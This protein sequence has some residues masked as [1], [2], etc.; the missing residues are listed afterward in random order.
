[1]YP[2]SFTNP[3]GIPYKFT[4]TSFS[5]SSSPQKRNITKYAQFFNE[6]GYKQES[7][8]LTMQNLETIFGDEPRLNT[9]P[10]LR[11]QELQ[12]LKGLK[13]INCITDPKKDAFNFSS[14]ST[15]SLFDQ[16]QASGRNVFPLHTP[17]LSLGGICQDLYHK[18]SESIIHEKNERS[19]IY[20]QKAN[21][22]KALNNLLNTPSALAS[23]AGTAVSGKRRGNSS[24]L[25]LANNVRKVSP[26]TKKFSTIKEVIGKPGNTPARTFTFTMNSGIKS[27]KQEN[28]KPLS[29]TIGAARSETSLSKER[30][31]K[32]SILNV[33]QSRVLESVNDLFDGK[34]VKPVSAMEMGSV[35]SLRPVTSLHK[36]VKSAV[37]FGQERPKKKVLTV[38]ATGSKVKEAAPFIKLETDCVDSV[39]ETGMAMMHQTKTK[40]QD[41]RV[42]RGYNNNG[43]LIRIEN[44][45]EV[46]NVNH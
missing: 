13:S 32:L 15:Y 29:P 42:A 8:Q 23:K 6:A 26:E 19:S 43:Y 14:P 18:Q 27:L 33:V 38:I 7:P 28:L 39:D 21:S 10:S 5:A 9:N 41:M 4:K 1:M 16:Y 44:V 17:S 40:P 36:N 25:L 11:F 30:K 46:I 20:T 24:D 22:Y 37:L 35:L 2:I 3:E 45:C 34:G 12:S 31:P